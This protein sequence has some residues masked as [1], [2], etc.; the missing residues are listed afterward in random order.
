MY[1]QGLKYKSRTLYHAL[2]GWH[3]QTRRPNENREINFA[4][5]KK[6]VSSAIATRKSQNVKI[7]SDKWFALRDRIETMKKP[8]MAKQI[9][10]K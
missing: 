5:T 1:V 4:K 10:N 8:N 7:L 9:T 3:M 6:K 2:H